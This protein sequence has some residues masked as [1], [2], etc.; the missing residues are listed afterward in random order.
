MVGG[1]RQAKARSAADAAG[2]ELASPMAFVLMAGRLLTFELGGRGKTKALLNDFA[3]GEIG[4]IEVKRLG[5]GGSVTLVLRGVPVKL[6][7]R[8]GAARAFAAQLERA[9]ND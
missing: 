1:S 5:L 3:L 7:S 2:I 8:V 9:R 6:E 4:G